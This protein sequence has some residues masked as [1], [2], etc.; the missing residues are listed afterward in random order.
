MVRATI[1]ALWLMLISTE[2]QN[3]NNNEN[4]RFRMQCNVVGKRV[5][6]KYTI[7]YS[8]CVRC[9]IEAVRHCDHCNWYLILRE[10]YVITENR[11][12][13]GYTTIRRIRYVICFLYVYKDTHTQMYIKYV[14][15]I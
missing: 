14:P 15:N 8:V 1:A 6:I 4:Y 9:T 7:I 5:Y 11:D 3:N 12:P 13:S 10:K 2:K